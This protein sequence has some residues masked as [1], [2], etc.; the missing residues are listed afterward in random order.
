MTSIA[1]G[2]A[3]RLLRRLLPGVEARAW[4]QPVTYLGVAMLAVVYGTVTL[5]AVNAR[6][7][8]MANAKRQGENL[9]RIIEQSYSHI[10]QSVD[11]SLLFLR[12]AY[13]NNP[14]GFDMASWANDLS[15]N[16]ELAFNFVFVDAK[17]RA[18][19]ATSRNA[20]RPNAM[21][22]VDFSDREYFQRHKNSPLDELEF[23]R[24]LTLKISGSLAIILTR[25]ITAPDGTFAGIVAALVNPVELGKTA[26][27]INLGPL[28]TFGLLGLDGIVRVR[29]VEGKADL[30]ISGQTIGPTDGV[31]SHIARARSGSFWNSPGLFDNTSRLVSYRALDA[32]PMIAVVAVTEDEVY[33]RANEVTAIYIGIA[34]LLTVVI[35]IAIRWGMTRQHN[36]SIAIAQMK[37]AQNEA[38]RG[39]ER[40]RLVEEAVN[41]GIW[42][43]DIVTDIDYRSTRW[44]SILG[45]ADDEIRDGA[46]FTRAL[47]HPDDKAAV[48][49][50]VA[51]HLEEGKP[52]SLEFRFRHKNGDYRW[53]HSRGKAMRDASGRQ[54]RMLGSMTDITERRNSELRAQESHENLARAERLA[55]L[56]HYKIDRV[57]GKLVWS[58]G[59]FRI[60]GLSS[61][62]Y[63]PTLQNALELIHPDDRQILRKFRDDAMAGQEIPHITMRAFRSDGQ[64][65][66]VEYWSTP[67]R[68]G[69]GVVTGIFGTLQ[70]VTARKRVEEALAR[71]NQELEARVSERTAEL[72]QEMRRREEA[73][74]TLGQM[75]KMEAVGQLTAGIA[76]D[77]NNLLAVIGGSLEFVDGA[78]ARGLTA[79]PELI[80]AALRATRRGRELVRRLLAFSRQ[81]PLRAEAT[82]IDQLVL[83]TLRLLQRTLGQG[84]DM[85]TR[86]DAEAAV[87][88]VDR[89]QMANALLNLA[90]NARDA[91]PEGGQLTIATRCR[92]V[93]ADAAG[94]PARWPTGEEVCIIISDTGVG[95]TDDVR[96]RA[97]EPFFTTKADGLGSG[98]G[99]SMVQGF[100]EQ[101][102]GRI[103]IESAP[104]NGTTVTIRLPRI[105]T[106]S[107]ADENDPVTGLTIGGRDKTVLLVEDDL[108][109]RV[110][111]AAQLKQ[112][113]YKVHAVGN[114][115]EAI[116]LIAS[117]ANIDIT[118][119]DIVL[120]GGLDGVALL[121]ETMRARP[122]MGVLCMSGYDPT[123]KHRKWLEIQNINFLEK[124]FSSG[125]LAQ[126]LDA[127]LAH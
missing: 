80:D 36:L 91:M 126:A 58:E 127:A 74:M 112:L 117:P 118:L 21:I 17:G 20:T 57:S 86:L 26:A 7:E 30:S 67:V 111:T 84:T 16:N 107:R 76:H 47:I 119:T 4:A 72:A 66:D 10:F 113:G 85:V 77:F 83:D 40:Y 53:V 96:S 48:A 92:P 55:L 56:G 78:A 70:D 97:F 2:G 108:D 41:D 27:G 52:F 54:V 1:P 44:K 19:H 116:D 31:L 32:F 60:F 28:G 109:V 49:A 82:T 105:A 39:E 100:V 64:L 68:D 99:L 23:S 104:G 114:G 81:S 93:S 69:D 9:V 90:L 46:A 50:A 24:P 59:I 6:I 18:I 73:Q 110:V 87:I 120:P 123:Q 34:L 37:E 8:A 89:N 35:L 29:A 124:P 43:W 65:I 42:D 88:S 25:R 62:T 38:R 11:S 33:R 122:R 14:S 61:L 102:G 13:Q 95:M 101:S 98:L 121:K 115:M 45:Y 79:E 3:F 106:E 12:H 94:G 63:Q 5:F 22:G 75:Q 71:V 103:D 15:F 51:A 125:L